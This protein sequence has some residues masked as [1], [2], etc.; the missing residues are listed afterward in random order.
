MKQF[1]E[2]LPTEVENPDFS[3]GIFLVQKFYSAGRGHWESGNPMIYSYK[4]NIYEDPA[5]RRVLEDLRI[6]GSQDTRISGSQDPWIPGPQGAP[7]NTPKL[8][9]VYFPSP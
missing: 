9:K 6:P 1:G 7:E 3:H 2:F 4:G 8:R 5:L